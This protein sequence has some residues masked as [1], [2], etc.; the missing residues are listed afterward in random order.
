MEKNLIEL[1]EY[2]EKRFPTPTS[3]QDLEKEGFNPTLLDETFKHGIIS[4]PHNM[5]DQKHKFN[6]DK[7]IPVVLNDKGMMM[8]GQA[9]LDSSIRRFDKSSEKTAKIMIW[10]SVAMLILSLVTI[11]LMIVG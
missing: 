3:R 10:L 9:K 5:D 6:F 7:S 1:L 11:G 2:L 8:L 4:C